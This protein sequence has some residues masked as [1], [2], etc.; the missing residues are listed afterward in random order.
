M[1]KKLHG[2]LAI[3]HTPFTDADE[4]DDLAFK[5]AVDWAFAV[6][7]DGIGTGMVSETLRL[8]DHERVYLANMLVEFAAGRGPVF[9]AVG[10][11][12]TKQALELRTCGRT[13]GC[14]AVMAVPPLT[15]KLSRSAPGRSLPR[16]RRRHRHPGDRA[17]RI[18]VRR[19]VDPHPGVS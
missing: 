14:D 10:A 17:G 1:A 9:V 2:V 12:S 8:T 16:P 7:A 4:I 15:A 3:A 18:R 13:A 6:G 19:A 5:R 11:E